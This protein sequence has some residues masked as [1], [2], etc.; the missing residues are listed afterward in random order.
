MGGEGGGGAA[1][2]EA[3]EEGG[4]TADNPSL[5][6]ALKYA[7]A[8][9]RVFPLRRM[10]KIPATS[11]GWHDGST[12]R[13]VI[14]AWWGEHPE[15]GVGFVIPDDMVI[16]DVDEVGDKTLAAHGLDIPDTARVKTR[17][18]H[19]HYY[20]LKDHHKYMEG[21]DSRKKRKIAFLPDID[22]LVHGYVLAPPTRHP[23][24]FEYA[25]E[26]PLSEETIEYAPHWIVAALEEERAHD[27]G[28]PDDEFAHGIEPGQRQWQLFRRACRMCKIG[29]SR[30][31]AKAV[32]KLLAEKSGSAD[33]DTDKMVDR[34]WEEYRAA[35]DRARI[36][37]SNEGTKIWT[38]ADLLEETT[39]P[40]SYLIEGMLHGVGYAV[41]G[42]AQGVGKSVLAAQVA[43]AVAT[44]GR[45]FGRR[46]EKA[47]VLYLD[48]E[49]EDTGAAE[50]WR[51]LLRGAGL[52]QAPT[53]LHTAFTWGAL[54]ERALERIGEFVSDHPHVRLV[55]IDTLS[56]FFPEE[57]GGGD[58]YKQDGRMM[59]KF[60]RFCRD[61]GIAML[62]VHHSKKPTGGKP[63]TFSDAF[64][65]SRAIPGMAKA[66][67]VLHRPDFETSGLLEIGGKLPESKIELTF[68]RDNLMWR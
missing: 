51:K 29:N 9:F 68:D 46:C 23:T 2:E 34:V 54:D 8:G 3:E 11:N 33:Y 18:G 5:E 30:G 52:D 17:R 63:D 39:E 40:P 59:K 20:R 60:V 48:L 41:L 67:W 14:R 32:L 13:D 12:A 47:G 24:G 27:K 62:L 38:L 19:H 22:V 44:G 26:V 57:A 43:I 28:L 6:A 10:T 21:G 37:E 7:K 16:L 35:D 1:T 25:W 61:Y 31:E 4:M 53:N 65:G 45:L 15:F 49:Q 55:I 42:A 50:R 36:A 58:A 56:F 66:R 64:S